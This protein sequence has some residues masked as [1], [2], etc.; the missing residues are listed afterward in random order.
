MGA[1]AKV[2]RCSGRCTV[3]ATKKR[4]TKLGERKNPP[5]G[6]REGFDSSLA[7]PHRDQSVC[8]SCAAENP[9]AHECYGVH[10]WIQVS[11]QGK[12]GA[13]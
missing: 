1:S 5:A 10:F 11:D 6:W 8:S 4:P 3:I 2:V 7:C 12:V 13:P 9:E